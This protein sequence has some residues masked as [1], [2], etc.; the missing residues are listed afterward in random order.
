MLAFMSMFMNV[1]EASFQLLL[2]DKLTCFNF[3][4]SHRQ[5]IGNTWKLHEE[6]FISACW[7]CV[8]FMPKL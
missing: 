4:L 1:N 7:S 2:C 8:M 5:A 6:Q 3:N